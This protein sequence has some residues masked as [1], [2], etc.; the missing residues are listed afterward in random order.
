MNTSNF[1]QHK[2]RKR[3]EAAERQA[4]SDKL[5]FEQKIERLDQ[6]FGKDKGATKERLKLQ[7]KIVSSKR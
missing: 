5:T 6:L 7:Q 3:K 2:D 4:A 1:P